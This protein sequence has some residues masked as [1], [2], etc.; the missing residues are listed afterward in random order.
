MR[1]KSNNADSV[2]V[3]NYGLDFLKIVATIFIV[4]HH[5]Q[6]C[7]DIV[8]PTGVNFNGPFW[9]YWGWLVELF[10]MISG[11]VTYRYVPVVADGKISLKDWYVKRAARLLPLIAVSVFVYEAILFIHVPVCGGCVSCNGKTVSLWGS[12]ITCLGIQSGGVFANP[13]INNPTWYVSGLLIMYT[14]FYIST[15]VSRKLR[16]PLLYTYIFIVLLG[17]GLITYNINLPFLN[18][19]TG[20]GYSCFFMGLLLAMYVKNYGV[21]IRLSLLCLAVTVIYLYLCVFHCGPMGSEQQFLLTF[22]LYPALVLL[23]ESGI[24]KKLFSHGIWQKWGQFSYNT[25]IW[26]TPMLLALNHLGYY[27]DLK[28]YLP[29]RWTMIAFCIAAEIVGII[30]HYGIEK[31]LDRLIKRMVKTN[32]GNLCH[33]D[34][35]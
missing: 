29:Y 6:Q 15:V 25:Y 28:P 23:T 10:F 33:A 32:N 3:R 5:Y 1:V 26:H 31:P 21:S 14:V 12:L 8:Y 13:M 24:A 18:V 9:F 20:R 30:S 27:W 19:E 17:C 35:A 22:V 34:K 16:V 7:M 11:Y 4:F 2:S